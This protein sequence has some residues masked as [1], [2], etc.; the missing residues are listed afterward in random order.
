MH[1]FAEP[2]YKVKP[3]TKWDE[4]TRT[5]VWV[6]QIGDAIAASLKKESA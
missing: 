3:V 1:L 2:Q 4:S 5:A 6:K